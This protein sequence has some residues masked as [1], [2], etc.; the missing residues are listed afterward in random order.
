MPQQLN[1][2]I[3]MSVYQLPDDSYFA[4]P[5]MEPGN[6]WFNRPAEE[7]ARKL[8][9]YFEEEFSESGQ[10]VEL[11]R[12]LPD[13]QFEQNRIYVNFEAS[14]RNLFPAIELHFDMFQ[15]QVL[16]G[17]FLGF[18]PILG[19]A[20]SGA[21]IE[22][23]TENM[24]GNIRLHISRTQRINYVPQ[25][26]SS[27]V[28]SQVTFSAADVVVNTHSLNE[29]KNFG[30]EQSLQILPA[31]ARAM[32]KPRKTAYKLY[33]EWNQ[34]E[35]A[36]FGK[37]S[38]SVLVTGRSGVGKSAL[39]HEFIYQKELKRYSEN[40]PTFWETN[41]SF[42]INKLVGAFGWQANFSVLCNE[43]RGRR[44]VLY[45]ENF[46]DLFEVGQYE[47]NNSSVADFLK[48]YLK[49][50]DLSLITECTNE[51]LAAIELR[52][53]GYSA[54]FHIIKLEEP[55]EDDLLTIIKLKVADFAC[56][57]KPL[58]VN[59]EAIKLA[60]HLQKRFTPYS[61]F[62]G[63]TIRF[64]DDLIN[65]K[66]ESA[67]EITHQHVMDAFCEE[68][69]MPGALIDPEAPFSFDEMEAHF[70]KNIFGQEEAVQ[71]VVDMLAT[72]KA[73]LVR[74]GKPIAS[75]LFIGPTGVG[76]TELAK[77][78]AEYVFG[79][80][81]KVIRYD[82]SEFSDLGAV[83]RL[84][85]N[86]MSS[87]GLLVD[88]VRQEPFS[89]VL[90][91][92]LEKAHPV[93]FDLLLQILGEGRLT[94]AKGNLADF[95]STIIIMTSNIGAR[96]MNWS[97]SGFGRKNQDV[98]HVAG[99]F[100]KEVQKYFRPELFNRLDR[101]VS[102]L[103][104]SREVIRKVV[105]REI[106]LV[107]KRDGI[108]FRKVELKIGVK[109]LDKLGIDGYDEMYGAR[110]LQR[111]IRRD[112]II[113]LAKA[114]NGFERDKSLMAEVVVEDKLIKV[115]ATEKIPG[116]QEKKEMAEELMM[117]NLIGDISKSRREF[118]LI[119]NGPYFNRI[120]S[121]FDILFMRR[122]KLGDKFFIEGQ[123]VK[124][125]F[126][127]E[128]MI[129]TV[130]ITQNQIVE[131]EIEAMKV[132]FELATT[133]KELQ[134]K[135]NIW[136]ETVYATK[137]M[138][139]K[140]L[141][142]SDN[143]STLAIYGNPK[144]LGEMYDLYQHLIENRKFT[145]TLWGVFINS[146]RKKDGLYAYKKEDS[147]EKILKHAFDDDLVGIEIEVSGDA[148][149]LYFKEEQGITEFQYDAQGSR[150]MVMVSQPGVKKFQTPESIHRKQ[151][152]TGTSA[153]KLRR[154]ISKDLVED[155]QYKLKIPDV[156]NAHLKI[157]GYLDQRFEEKLLEITCNG[158]EEK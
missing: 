56:L 129:D 75:L 85:G 87:S 99:H 120:L 117:K 103:P 9:K 35:D 142:P 114:L 141:Y 94:D 156:K 86:S 25:L 50:G 60:L 155:K 47:G 95:C 20:S 124:D 100:Q 118:Q 24:K 144:Y 123:M 102:F 91:D 53:P 143:R 73:G 43:L 15:S 106:G 14:P 133:N 27:Q 69:G 38:R 66:H 135:Y 83:L 147:F 80:R 74:E 158:R 11:M 119:L 131:I 13:I 126:D 84:T 115:K 10:Y 48:E 157:A 88:A 44:D 23:L 34:I 3:W 46:A 42:L 29:L 36:M 39:I 67:K 113:P 5:I 92:E 153:M 137:L 146:S 41:A 148:V 70:L 17:V 82:M 16:P 152:F 61:G 63:K 93:F 154:I 127:L 52:S 89:V 30:G 111:V 139:Y 112:L 49:R 125:F 31:A 104:L 90:F 72:V 77:V 37:F 140:H 65:E 64:F 107:K 97:V 28:F 62:P 116:R 22:D 40:A 138:L 19:V 109:A 108:F 2:K 128:K 8:A 81:N 110:H 78:L 33:E 122:K 54:L 151:A 45:V 134:V 32:K 96:N 7:L 145:T 101:I 149:H 58:K 121:R 51:Q 98:K 150:Y 21:T 130:T 12:K 79:N 71:T 26:M 105:D 18:V 6:V 57:Y 132:Y 4:I 55:P 59:E 76:K 1:A 68:T 136:L